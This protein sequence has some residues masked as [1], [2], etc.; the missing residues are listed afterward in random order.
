MNAIFFILLLISS[1]PSSETEENSS[2]L[3][4]ASDLEQ[5]NSELD[6][7]SSRWSEWS[8]WSPCSRSCD[9]GVARQ[10]RKCQALKCRGEYVR[11]KICNMQLCPVFRDFREE[12]CGAFNSVLYQGS[13]F[14]WSAEY[15]ERNPC[16]LTCR[17]KA[18]F[19]ND[20][21]GNE[22]LVVVAQLNDKVEDGTRCRQGSLDMCIDGKCLRVGCDLRIGSTLQVDSCGN[23]GG[24][25]SSCSQPLYHWTLK[26][27]SLCSVTCGGGYK[28]SRP[29]C[30]NILTGMEV[31]EQ[32]CNDSLKPDTTVVECNI[33]NCPPRWHTT[34]WGACSA[35]C[36]GGTRFR[37]VYC[38][39]DRGNKTKVKVSEQ[40]CPGRK[41]RYQEPCNQMV[42]PKWHTLPWSGCSVSCGEGMQVRVVECR[43]ADDFPSS[44]CPI[45]DEPVST[46]ACSTGIQ[47]PHFFD[48]VEEL[49]PG[50]Y[51]T[52]PLIQPYPPPPPAHAEK[53]IGEQV[54]P[55]ESTFIADEWGPCSVS[56][57]DGIRKREVH[58][59]IFLEFSR[60]IAKLPDSQCSGPKPVVTERCFMEPCSS[61]RIDIKDD[62]YRADMPIKVGSGSPGT[63]YTWKE[64]GYTHCSASCLGGVQELIV[65]CVRDDTQKVTSP[66]MCPREFKPEVLVRTC[67]DHPCP[68]RWNYSDFQ[69][70]TQSCGI[71]IQTREVTCI[72]EVTQGGGNTVIVPSNMCPQPP[73]PDRQNCN[74]LDC[75]VRWKL[76][77][78]SKCTKN[79]GGGEKTRKVECKQV[80]AQ[81]HTVDRPASM[82]PTPKPPDKKPCNTKSCV[83]ETDKPQIEVSNSTFIQH[84]PKKKKVSL[85]VGGAATIFY[86]SMIKIKCPVKRFNRTKIQWVKDHSYLPKVKKYKVSKKGALRI[87]NLTYKDSGIYT[88]MA[89]KSSADLALSVKP[90]PGE[91]PTSEEIQ[92]Q[93]GYK[94]SHRID[95]AIS[96]IQAGRD[97]LNPVFGNDDHS[98]EQKPDKPKKNTTPRTRIIL[99]TQSTRKGTSNVGNLN[100]LPAQSTTLVSE[101]DQSRI[102]P[103][104]FPSSSDSLKPAASSSGT[105]IIPHFQQLISNIQTFTNSRGHR[106]VTES[107]SHPYFDE[108]SIADSTEDDYGSV[109]ILGKGTPDSVRFEWSASEWSKCSQACGEGFQM[110]EVKCMVL[111]HNTS[112]EVENNFCEDAGLPV[113][114]NVEKCEVNDCAQWITSDWSACHTSKCLTLNTAI[115]RRKVIC[116]NSKNETFDASRCNAANKPP[117]RQECFKSTCR[118]LWRAGAWSQCSANCDTR[119]VKYRVL[120]CVWQGTKRSAGSACHNQDRPPVTKSCVGPPCIFKNSKEVC[121]DRSRYCENVKLMDLCNDLKY[122]H[123]C[124]YTCKAQ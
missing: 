18:S 78:W 5:N 116:Q 56:C 14:L 123:Q 13:L 17:G 122:Q 32:L 30:Q 10:F 79:C 24:D 51:H 31:E 70:C 90:R 9:G 42:C 27:V 26:S 54:I 86:G 89:G 1:R 110:R 12:Q 85:K 72:H 41:P 66:Y 64:Q 118:P 15:D 57:G 34:D 75:P 33:H 50:L 98:H 124:C 6:V 61:E 84:D 68:P 67:N 121:Y 103:S 97:E 76:T 60:T 37:Q 81:N 117:H 82:C 120:Q 107:S 92:K 40:K 109:V 74:V 16:S 39:E 11:Y 111:L 2:Q 115:Q 29:V 94:N 3:E 48:S 28:M 83:L 101:N 43:N 52:Q 44:F 23:C 53:L 91:F 95:L 8:E 93:A 100:A 63:T 112:Q 25:G 119:S 114:A 38:V 46:K 88:C 69:P 45:I 71:G 77:E 36:G 22:P 7:A 20:L 59:K 96:D 104:N 87:L 65:N 102:V 55:S 106:M 19:S 62:P 58:C 21:E 105:R 73:P 49:L 35:T 113:P 80:M 108:P 4:N 47:C 99:P